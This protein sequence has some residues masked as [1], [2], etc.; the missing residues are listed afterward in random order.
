MGCFS[1]K[2]SV[3]KPV[4][5]VQASAAGNFNP[6]EHWNVDTTSLDKQV[7]APT[8]TPHANSTLTGSNSV[9]QTQRAQVNGIPS[10][11]LEQGG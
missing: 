1:S 4:V 5:A 6:E 11:Q 2:D 10:A 7:R 3:K 9:Q 8:S